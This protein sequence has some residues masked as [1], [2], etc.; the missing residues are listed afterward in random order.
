MNILGLE[1]EKYSPRDPDTGG[2]VEELGD[3]G[4]GRSLKPDGGDVVEKG[5]S[6]AEEQEILRC[7]SQLPECGRVITK[8]RIIGG[9]DADPGM[10]PWQASLQQF[11]FHFCGGSLITNEW[12][13]TAAHCISRDD[14]NITDIHLG[15][16]QLDVSSPD[17][18]NRTRGEIIC[19]PDYDPRTNN[20]DICLLKLSA[21]V[22]FTN[23]IRP[24]CLASEDSTIH[25]GL[26]SWVTGFGVTDNLSTSNTLQEVNVPIVGNNRCACY[27]QPSQINKNM[28]C[29]GYSDGGKDSCQGDS[30]GPLT[31]W[32]YVGPGWSLVE[33]KCFTV[34][35]DLRYQYPSHH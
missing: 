15:V 32:H 8:N 31:K 27:N 20:N 4:V 21:P 14:I 35:Y 9:Q 28:I 1:L 30:G 16:L 23:Y 33:S 29:A 19:H 3:K 26:T 7:Q 25:D 11:G 22:S 34:N 18:V 13:L 17:R 5:R 6:S 2:R 24:I 10:W 12:V